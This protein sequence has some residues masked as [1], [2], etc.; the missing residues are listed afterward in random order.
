[1]TGSVFISYRREDSAGYARAIYNELRERLGAEKI[2]MD[3]DAIEPGLDFVEAIENAV[4]KCDVLLALIGPG[5]LNAVGEA[6]SRLHQSNDY[7]RSEIRTALERDIRVIPVL[8]GG[9][10]MPGDDAI[11]PDLAP[12]L[13]RNAIEI[14]HTH[15][16]AD[17]ASLVRV[18]LKLVDVAPTPTPSVAPQPAPRPQPV[19]EPAAPPGPAYAASP[20]APAAAPQP[21][22]TPAGTRRAWVG[23]L[24]MAAL[25]TVAGMML[26]AL[27]DDMRVG[28]SNDYRT[29]PE[30]NAAISALLAGVIG[31]VI[32]LIAGRI[33]RRRWKLGFTVGIAGFAALGF[34]TGA[35]TEEMLDVRYGDDALSAAIAVWVFGLVVIVTRMLWLRR[36]R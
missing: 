11:P 27:F 19:A 8:L 35:W 15:F 29:V 2:F 10:S 17:V 33:A 12:L 23:P 21:A 16:D 13:R 22:P 14:R 32:T 3:V 25:F 28:Y 4:G 18:L 20:G 5:W 9:A 30:G 7:V 24:A 6:P 1:M 36:A 34:A 26:F 31:F